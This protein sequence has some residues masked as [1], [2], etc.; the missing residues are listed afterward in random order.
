MSQISHNAAG[1]GGGGAGV[2]TSLV[3]NPGPTTLTGILTQTGTAN[4]NVSG[5]ADTNI[6]TGSSGQ[7]NIGNPNSLTDTFVNI[8]VTP[9]GEIDIGD[10][11]TTGSIFI[12]Q[13]LSN[14]AVNIGTATS[15]VQI[16]A[17][18]GGGIIYLLAASI[19]IDGPTGGIISIGNSITT[20]TITIGNGIT[21]GTIN[22]G[23]DNANGGLIAIGNQINA[24]VE[25]FG[26]YVDIDSSTTAGGIDIGFSM[27]NGPITIGQA[28]N[29]GS[30]QIGNAANTSI[31]VT[32]S[33]MTINTVAAGTIEIGDSITT[34]S[35]SIATG[36][37]TGS[38]TIGG[39][40]NVRIVPATGGAASPAT[41]A[42]INHRVGVATFTGF[43][44]APAASQAFTISNST[45]ATT[46]FI[47][48]TVSNLNASTNGALMSLVAITQSASQIVVHTTNNGPGALGSGDNVLISFVVNS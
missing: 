29:G 2:F 18:G 47:N 35:M 23:V 11:M 24:T 36:L 15:I 44:T 45:I 13:G 43:T 19:D 40:G 42:T 33:D 8:D 34:G 37:T 38:L 46:S 6:G 20:G 27:T 12:G 32:T 3:V 17:F 22:I 1:G 26:S 10:S 9:N 7:I 21:S 48:V 25:I 31:T 39:S 5:T 41:S 16:G 14:G 28:N 30:V 4:I